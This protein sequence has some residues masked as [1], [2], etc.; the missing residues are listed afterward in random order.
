MKVCA[1]GR[2]DNDG[3][4]V[5]SAAFR[6]GAVECDK[7]KTRAS[8]VV[9]ALM[10]G[11]QQSDGAARKQTAIVD[12]CVLYRACTEMSGATW[13]DCP[14]QKVGQSREEC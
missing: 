14:A 6:V 12:M 13:T 8:C 4:F 5:R 2:C 1:P 9:D 3:L 11:Y 7:N 10:V